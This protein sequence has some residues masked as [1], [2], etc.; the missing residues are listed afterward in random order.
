IYSMI[1][2]I[3]G[4]GG[5]AAMLLMPY[6]TRK[7][8]KR[9]LQIVGTLT[10]IV[11]LLVIFLLGG[12]S[13]MTSGSVSKSVF[14]ASTQ[15]FVV[16][17]AGMLQLINPAMDGDCYDYQQYISGY[18]LEGI[19]G[20]VTAWTAGI[21][22]QLT[23]YIPTFIQRSIGFQQGEERFQSD[24]AFLPDNMAIIDRWFNTAAIITLIASLLYMI[25][26]LFYSLDE[27]KHKQIIEELEARAEADKMDDDF[28]PGTAEAAETLINGESAGGLE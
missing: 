16:F 27:K 28:I 7:M 5:S 24:A 15:V 3:T 26:Y 18:R 6:F 1:S 20:M 25:I 21:L 13:N 19:M 22:G 10:I 17:T 4:L 11:P 8:S 9:N 12:F 14:L 23:T 2:L